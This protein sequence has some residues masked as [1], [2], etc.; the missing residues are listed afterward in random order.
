MAFLGKTS[1]S[2]LPPSTGLAFAYGTTMALS[3]PPHGPGSH[4]GASPSKSQQEKGAVGS[5]FQPCRGSTLQRHR[6][7]KKSFSCS[8]RKCIPCSAHALTRQNVLT[9]LL[10]ERVSFWLWS[11]PS[12]AS[13]LVE[14]PRAARWIQFPVAVAGRMWPSDFRQTCLITPRTLP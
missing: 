2:L 3:V 11:L 7:S 10:H 6:R 4:S 12:G 9:R 13:L 5:L 14:M 1:S 8:V